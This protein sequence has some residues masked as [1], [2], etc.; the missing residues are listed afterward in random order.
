MGRGRT[1]RRA[2]LATA[3]TILVAITSAL[4]TPAG[5]AAMVLADGREA[6]GGMSHGRGS[7]GAAADRVPSRRYPVSVELASLNPAV[8]RQGGELRIS[9]R[10]TNTSGRRVGA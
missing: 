9:G 6:D 5:S 8:V 3:T 2:V 4:S 10:V 7:D 1:Y